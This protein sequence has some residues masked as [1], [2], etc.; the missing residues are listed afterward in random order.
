MTRGDSADHPTA[1]HAGDPTAGHTGEGA[2]RRD[3]RPPRRYGELARWF[4][5]VTRPD[6]YEEEAAFLLDLLSTARGRRP[7]TLLELG[8]GGG[9]T[10]W[11][12]KAVARCTLTDVSADMLDVSR[13][14][15]PECEHVEGDMRS[16]RLGRTFDAVLVHDACCYLVTEEEL[17]QLA[18]TAAAHLPAGGAVLVCPDH[19][20]E[21]FE[22]NTRHGGHDGPDGRA[23]RYVSRAWDPDPADSTTT[24]AVA[25]LMVEAD[26]SVRSAHDVHLYGLF[27]ERTWIAALRGAG[28]DARCLTDDWDRRVFLGIRRAE[29]GTD[30]ARPGARSRPAS[31]RLALRARS[32]PE[33]R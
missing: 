4:P 3:D 9:N 30:R 17:A 7:R 19:V 31:G 18:A 26:G 14:I 21:T 20:R 16:L 10:A 22:P 8:S 24:V 15:N 25:Y 33:H 5:L 11:H 6:E 2:A 12:L 27:P 32:R 29:E 13:A 1:G 23:L 28:F